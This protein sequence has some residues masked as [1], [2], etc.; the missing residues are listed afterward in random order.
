MCLLKCAKHFTQGINH[1]LC[2]CSFLVVSMASPVQLYRKCSCWFE[3]EASSS[4]TF[5]PGLDCK[6]SLDPGKRKQQCWYHCMHHLTQTFITMDADTASTL[7]LSFFYLLLLPFFFFVSS[8][9]YFGNICF[10]W[11][12]LVCEIATLINL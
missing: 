11:N 2:I 7:L 9:F 6:V 3:D 12:L 8:F 5:L 10:F 1:V 4:E